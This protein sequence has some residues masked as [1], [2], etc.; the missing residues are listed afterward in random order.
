MMVWMFLG[1]F[2][3][4]LVKFY[5]K[6]LNMKQ[7]SVFL[8]SIKKNLKEM[9]SSDWESFSNQ[10]LLVKIIKILLLVLG[11]INVFILCCLCLIRLL[12]KLGIHFGI[13]HHFSSI[14]YRKNNIYESNYTELEY[15]AIH[16]LL[17]VGYLDVFKIDE[18]S[19]LLD[20]YKKYLNEN[21]PN[22]QHNK[23]YKKISLKRKLIYCLIIANSKRTLSLILKI[24]N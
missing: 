3:F 4:Y 1:Y 19:E 20:Q 18:K 23:Y 24:L 16:H 7:I 21:F 15:T 22:W 12:L 8:N 10:S 17:Y 14:L 2:L 6:T 13:R 5:Y 9:Y 11:A